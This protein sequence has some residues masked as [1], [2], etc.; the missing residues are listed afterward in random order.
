MGNRDFLLWIILAL[1]IAVPG[2]E[3]VK[4]IGRD[5]TG[6]GSTIQE[7]MGGRHTDK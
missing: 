4:G 3:T 7:Q 2:C 6:A 1:V 5:I